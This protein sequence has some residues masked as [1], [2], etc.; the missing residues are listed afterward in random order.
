MIK[1]LFS[2]CVVLAITCCTPKPKNSKTVNNSGTVDNSTAATPSVIKE[3]PYDNSRNPFGVLCNS[4][5][6]TGPLSP[7]IRIAIGKELG[8][9]YLRTGVMITKWTGSTAANEAFVKSGFK[10]VMN[11]NNDPLGVGQ[12]PSP[13]P[14]DMV[15]YRKSISDIMDKYPAEVLVIEN[16]EA[17]D[18]Y[19]TGTADEYLKMLNVAIDE[20]H[21]K[22]L[23]V[24]NGGI[25]SRELTILTWKDFMNRGLTAQANAFG[26]AA[27]PANIL[28]ALPTLNSIPVMKE[29]IAEI[30]K[31]VAAY[32]VLPLDFVNFHWYEP[33]ILRFSKNAPSD[34][35][36]DHIVPGA[37]E[38]VVNY[39]RNATG[40]PVMSNEMGVVT[41]SANLVTE[42]LQEA[43]NLKLPY[44]MFYSGNGDRTGASLPI[45]NDNGTLLPNGVA[46]KDFIKTHYP[47][48]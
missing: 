46:F 30:E 4:S 38:A 26:K 36:P 14:S 22:G 37:M 44:V 35:S 1:D 21:K 15:A 3:L 33:I 39:L 12:P 8:V 27:I 42:L 48:K 45:H 9:N 24:T 6:G 32:K 41:S 25:T 2:F 16:E 31:L 18:K 11:I 34:A 40:K 23:R 17:N 20:A 43:Q 5:G 13:F 10:M 47:V 28:A 19:Y 29:R 7:Q